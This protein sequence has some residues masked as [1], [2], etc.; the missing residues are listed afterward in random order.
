[1]L[2]NFYY[3]VTCYYNLFGLQVRLL[4]DDSTVSVDAMMIE[5]QANEPLCKVCRPMRYVVERTP[6]FKL[7]DG[8]MVSQRTVSDRWITDK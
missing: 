7:E 6:P 2:S 5:S 8:T 3:Q 1:M 4:V